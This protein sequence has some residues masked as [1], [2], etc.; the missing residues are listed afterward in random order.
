M[1]EITKLVLFFSSLLR[2]KWRQMR[3]RIVLPLVSVILGVL[4][5]RLGDIQVRDVLKVAHGGAFE[6]IPFE[7]AQA[8]YVHY[9]LN[10]PAWAILREEHGSLRWSPSTY[11]TGRDLRYFLAVAV[12][13][14][15]L[16]LQLDERLK[17]AT[18]QRI[19]ARQRTWP[20]RIFALTCVLYGSF[21][22][23][24]ILPDFIPPKANG[25]WLPNRHWY[26]FLSAVLAWGFG[27]VWAG[28]RSLLG[29]KHESPLV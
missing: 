24:A 23:L 8:R 11:W 19:R 7:A 4:L 9:A 27:L 20:G 28:S 16:G 25:V 15:V 12:M 3:F 2:K 5:F 10:A 17:P 29:N 1:A 13:W 14:Y 21:V 18:A 26:W 22:C 6:G